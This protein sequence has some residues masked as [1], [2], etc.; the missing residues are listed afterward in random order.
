PGAQFL[1]DRFTRKF[2][3]DKLSS[4]LENILTNGRD[5]EIEKK[6][7]KPFER[8][9]W[10]RDLGGVV[11]P[12]IQ[13]VATVALKKFCNTVVKSVLVSYFLSSPISCREF[14]LS[15]GYNHL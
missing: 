12:C 7:K 13:N 4:D 5:Q 1:P 9:K 10:I 11:S 15:I 6:K 3:G 2:Y 14:F 8:E